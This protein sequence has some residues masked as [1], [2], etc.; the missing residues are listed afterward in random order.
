MNQIEKIFRMFYRKSLQSFNQ[1]HQS[2]LNQSFYQSKCCR[3]ALLTA[4]ERDE[5]PLNFRDFHARL[6]V[7]AST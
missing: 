3:P 4:S 7:S 1:P 6:P 2:F 5:K